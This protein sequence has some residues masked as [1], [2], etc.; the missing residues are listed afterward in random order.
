M[1]VLVFGM[2]SEEVSADDKLPIVAT[3]GAET[4]YTES[5]TDT[6]KEAFDEWKLP[7]IEKELGGEGTYVGRIKEYEANLN[8]FVFT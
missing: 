7:D 2:A 8:T 4:V 1:C 3:E 5:T 6:V